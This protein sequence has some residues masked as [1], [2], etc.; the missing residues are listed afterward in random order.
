MQDE[1]DN[2]VREYWKQVT[3]GSVPA[4][5]VAGARPRLLTTPASATRA[6][7]CRIR[8]HGLV[9]TGMRHKQ[10]DEEDMHSEAR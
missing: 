2:Y 7:R 8:R 3:R 4:S 9:L 1:L 6:R 5:A 10:V